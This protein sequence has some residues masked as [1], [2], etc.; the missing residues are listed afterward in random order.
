VRR[1]HL[2]NLLHGYHLG[3]AGT[4][5]GTIVVMATITAGSHGPETVAWELAVAVAVTV[6]V[7]WIAHVYAHTLAESLERGRRLDTAEF[8][9]I[10]K[11]EL[12]MPLAA[13][14]PVAVL[15]LSAVGLLKVQTATWLAMG[16]GVA[17]LAVQGAR[18]AALE[19]L[20]RAASIVAIALNVALGL[21]IVGL[22]ALVGH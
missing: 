13:V 9:S 16:V 19:S 6:L 7:F 20:G 4:V 1:R 21:V 17:T 18:Y 2:R 11:R 3:L 14:A 12:A 10:A 5:Y 15:V 8:T 22:K